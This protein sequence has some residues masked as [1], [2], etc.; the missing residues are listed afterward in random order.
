MAAET[1]ILAQ[2]QAHLQARRPAEAARLLQGLVERQPDNA[3]AHQELAMALAARARFGPAAQA[4]RRALE[5]DPSLARPHGLLA[6][7]ALNTGRFEEAASEYRALLAAIPEAETA[8]RAAVYNKLAMVAYR[9][10][11]YQESAE[12][13]QRALALDPQNAAYHFN[14]AMLYRQVGQERDCQSQLERLLALPEVLP[15]VAHAARFNLGHLYARRG[16]YGQARQQF[17]QALRL[18]RSFL[19][20]LFR[21][22]PFLARLELPTLVLLLVLA[23]AIV[24]AALLI[25]WR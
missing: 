1:D 3:L 6:W 4:A 19:G 21:Q 15:T 11:H 10:K 22:A 5:I 9:R 16:D 23:A 2:A 17:A 8:E 13:L 12:T 14:L 18:R 24:A 25:F 20:R 7:I